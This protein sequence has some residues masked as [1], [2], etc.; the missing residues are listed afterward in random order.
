MNYFPKALLSLLCS[1][2]KR[3]HRFI[4]WIIAPT[5]GFKD[6]CSVSKTLRGIEALN[7]IEKRQVQN[8]NYSYFDEA[9]YI[10]QLFGIVLKY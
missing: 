7:K 10:N 8:L 2:I 3:D 4:K 6:F 5:L 1:I 9:K